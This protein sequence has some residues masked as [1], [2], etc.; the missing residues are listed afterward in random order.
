MDSLG[1]YAATGCPITLHIKDWHQKRQCIVT[2]TY[3]SRQILIYRSSSLSILL[4][5]IL[6]H[7]ILLQDHHR[8]LLETPCSKSRQD[9]MCIQW[10]KL[11]SNEQDGGSWELTSWDYHSRST[12]GR[13]ARRKSCG[14]CSQVLVSASPPGTFPHCRPPLQVSHKPLLERHWNRERQA[15]EDTRFLRFCIWLNGERKMR[16]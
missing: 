1:I 4:F 2:L 6:P 5:E 12:L 10:S 14:C 3:H 11:P 9:S 16:W 13:P 8:P 7:R 15:E